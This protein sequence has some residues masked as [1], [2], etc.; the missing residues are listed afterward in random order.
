GWYCLAIAVDPANDNN[1]VCG[2]LNCYRTTNG[3]T[4]WTQVSTWVGT[5]GNY[6]HADQHTAV[7]NGNQVLVGSDGGIF[8]SANG[9]ATFTDRNTGLRLKQF[10]ACA[11]H[12]TTTNYFLAGAQDN[13]CHQLANAGLGSSVEVTGG[14]G[15]FVHIDQDQ[16]QYQF[17]SY[18]FSQYR[19]ST[20][21]G[22][23]WS[24][25]NY[26]TSAGQFI[27]PTDY[28]DGN[29]IMY[30]GGIAGQYVRWDDP[31]TGGTFTPVSIGAFSGASVMSV[32][33]SPYTSNRVF[34]GTNAGKV[35][36]TDNS[37]TATPTGTDVS[38]SGMTS[39]TVS[40]VAVGTT[41]NNLLAT[42][43]NYGIAHVWM[44]TT[45]GGSAGWTNISGNL[46]DIPVRWAMFYP[47]DDTKAI[48]A[49]EMG[50]YETSLINGAST[51]W[52]QDAG[53][54]VVRTDMLQYR[55]SDGTIAAAT[56]G[57][58]LWTT[59]LPIAPYI[60]Y[61]VNYGTH[62]EATTGT[63][64]CQGYKDYT[65]NMTI[66][67]APAGDATVTLSV[68][69]GG[70][71]T[72]GVDFDFTTNGNFAAPSNVLTFPNGSTTSQPVTIRVYDDAAVESSESFT[73]NYAVSGST[74]ALA[75]SGNP[76]YTMTIT[77]NDQAPVVPVASV[78][79]PI[80]SYSVSLSS[81][82][83]FRS[84]QQKHRIQALYLA[85]ELTT[86][87]MA[88]GNISALN[89]RVVTKNSTK[90]F[91]GY[92]ISM[93]NT[94]AT[95]LST[96]FSGASLTQVYTG[97]YT[98]V[99]GDNSFAFGTGAGSASTFVWDGVSNIVIQ[100]CF[101]N[102]PAAADALADVM[103]GS[104]PFGTGTAAANYA[105]T[106]SNAGAGS[107]CSLAAASISN[108]RVNVTFTA[109]LPGNPVES[110]LNASKTAYLGP[111]KDVYFY[112]TNG[113]VIARITN[114]SSFDYGCT[115]V[116]VDR[117]GGSSVQFWNNTAA[118][119]L[120]SKTIHV[121]PTNNNPTGQYQITLYY[122]AAEK[123]GWEAATSQSFGSIQMVKV[124]GQINQVTPATP[125]AAGTVLVVTPTT[126]TFGSDYTLTYTFSTGFSGF[127]AGIPAA[128]LPVTLL[129]FS[130]RLDNNT[131]PLSWSTSSEQ[132]SAYFEVQKS[133]D[134][135]SFYPLGKVAA[136]GNSNTERHYGYIDKQVS[137]QNYYRL[138]MTDIDGKF[139]FSNT[140]LVK[141]ANVLQ[142]VWVVNNP[143][144]NYIDIRLARL[145]QQQVKVELLTMSGTLA[146]VR[147]Y[148]GA[149]QVH[150]DLGG[151]SLSAG[152]YLLRTT[153]D[154][155]QFT[156]KVVKQ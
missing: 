3:G 27:N 6:V 124:A 149:V 53:F 133:V 95:N 59:S 32:M 101:D 30:T 111:N 25:V 22:A 137:E 68:A 118:N 97:N 71:A 120:M 77:D 84:N 60:R 15:A 47:D 156:N 94:P 115:Q 81:A 41:D 58:G 8:Y 54:P 20:D 61:Q 134:G 67:A 143:F 141:G 11:I 12:P 148:A 104:N 31:Q 74:N 110:T 88:A 132:N 69:G 154:G 92:T 131:I 26:S 125:N 139:V 129:S 96:G 140:V 79:F 76:A 82:T 23:S 36:K 86:A 130:G 135:T 49:T 57:R 91:T 19:R 150:V 151:S 10:Y 83:A 37:H 40:C 127:G 108:S 35:V 45:G 66:D 39:G 126:G 16:P 64:G 103:E 85:S 106:Y 42:Y 52:T 56:H 107:G 146:F 102:S 28:D 18:T 89:M 70:T 117:A 2:G 33:V 38:G 72:Q 112:N 73:L 17:G 109:G 5:T 147:A 90:A 105:S 1:V 123:T 153:V 34:F 138:K 98:S 43:S 51:V 93:A 55:R 65:V 75:A 142:Q 24:A 9:G 63:S 13:G 152:T 87:G 78:N 121:I 122:T 80:G 29:N 114:L 119:Y 155:K 62:A 48:L 44:S 46:P 128:A 99:A 116:T 113:D 21:G 144:R 7:W 145:P 100:F 50:V 14:D 136:A 4:S